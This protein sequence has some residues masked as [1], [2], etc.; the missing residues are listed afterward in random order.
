VSRP[1]V[2]VTPRRLDAEVVVDLW[3]CSYNLTDEGARRCRDLLEVAAR[4]CAT[5]NRPVYFSAG[6]SVVQITRVRRDE[7]D[8]LAAALLE[9]V[10]DPRHQ[11]PLRGIAP[12]LDGDEA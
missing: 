8:E 6:G 9:V 11:E 12:Q 4:R 2:T 3:P 7:A 1:R 10:L 5:K